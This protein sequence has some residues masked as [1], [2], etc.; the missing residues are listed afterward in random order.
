MTG[1]DEPNRAIEACRAAGL[2]VVDETDCT[3][4]LRDRLVVVARSGGLQ[5]VWPY[6]RR[7]PVHGPP[8]P[9]GTAAPAAAITIAGHQ[10][11]MGDA[12]S[13]R[14][15]TSTVPDAARALAAQLERQFGKDAELTKRLADAQ[16][17]LTRANDQ[18]WCGIHPDGLAT[19]Y[20]EHAAAVEIASTCNRSEVLDAP[21]PLAVVQQ[22]HWAIGGAFIA[23][24][25]AAE[26]RRQLA[27]DTGELIRQFVDALVTAGWT[28]E[29]ARN[30]NVHE[31]AA[32]HPQPRGGTND[33]NDTDPAVSDHTHTPRS[34][35]RG[36]E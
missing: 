5:I 27:A 12:E 31:L 8:G 11:G 16:Q 28:E 14:G 18:L 29:Q 36:P 26:E 3:C 10:T 30:A 35:H 1:A 13:R 2:P 21:D 22:A 6:D 7:C 32:E 17:R 4:S 20:G 34:G 9:R 15:M 25:A 19:V 23:Y 24:Q 33:G